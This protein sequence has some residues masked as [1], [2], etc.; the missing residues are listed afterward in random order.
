MKTIRVSGLVL[1]F[2]ALVVTAGPAGAQQA[3]AQAGPNAN[4]MVEIFVAKGY[5]TAE[6]AAEIRKA[7]NPAEANQR[8]LQVFLAKGMLTPEEYARASGGTAPAGG[9]GG[10]RVV[11]AAASASPAAVPGAS[12]PGPAEKR[13]LAEWPTSPAMAGTDPSDGTAADASVIPAIAPPRVLPIDVPRNPRGIIPDIKLGS[14]AMIN[15]YGFLKATAI[16]D[17]TNSGG[18][19]VGSNDF[20]L[21]LLQGDTGS[22]SGSQF[23]IKARSTRVGAN[24]YWPLGG[25][26]ITLTGKIEFDFEGDYTAVNNRNVSSSRSSQP[27]LRFAWM[28]MDAKW[29]EVPVFAEFGQEWSLVG[30][31]IVPDYIES[32]NNGVAFGSIYER[33]PQIRT[34]MQFHAGGLKIQP[35]FALVWASFADSNL[36]NSSTAAV[37]GSQGVVPTGQQ[38]QTREGAILGSASGQ[39]GVQGRVVFDFPI[40]KSW[41]GVP[42]AEIVISGGHAVAEE[43]VPVGNLPTTGVPALTAATGAAP[44]GL[45]AGACSGTAPAGGFSLRCSY[46]DGLTMRIPQNIGTVGFQLPTPWFTLWANYFRGGDMRFYF[47]G[48]LNSAF[49]DTAG[50]TPLVI[51]GAST[52]VTC[53]NPPACTT[54]GTTTQNQSVF[55]LAG[56]PISFRAVAGAAVAD[57]YRPI[58]GQGGFVQLGIPLSRIFGADPQGRNAGWRLYVAYGIDSAFSRDVIRTGGNNLDRTDYVPISLRYKINRWAEIV[59]E[60]TWYDTRTADSRTVLYRGIPAH[61]N[62]DIRNEFGTIFTF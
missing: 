20:P 52:L 26:D 27:S 50:V 58:R 3:P 14:G 40:H 2:A 60:T 1:V 23:R 36:N 5:L 47:A 51:P 24:F 45:G 22:S 21:P 54:T 11:N 4:T 10:A 17:T 33:Q 13:K 42:N 12:A 41:K 46:P 57:Q 43:V 49:V 56:D 35:E 29:G 31:S 6:E 30:T 61:V 7:P 15:L 9:G 25:P 19:V 38:E 59:N 34:G 55:S 39:P 53:T 44:N 8:M 18:A 48:I 37:L 32:T 16:Y 28:R 62:H